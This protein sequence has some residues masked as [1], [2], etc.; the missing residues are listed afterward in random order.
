MCM[1]PKSAIFDDITI[2][3]EMKSQQQL[4]DVWLE[5]K[6]RLSTYKLHI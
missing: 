4:L 2:N 3:Y 5:Q 1:C 6:E